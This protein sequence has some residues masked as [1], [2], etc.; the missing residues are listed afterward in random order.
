MITTILEITILKRQKEAEIQTMRDTCSMTYGGVCSAKI[1]CAICLIKDD[2]RELTRL[3]ESGEEKMDFGKI[4]MMTKTFV[5]YNIAFFKKLEDK[6]FN[7]LKRMAPS[8]LLLLNTDR[9]EMMVLMLGLE[10]LRFA[11]NTHFRGIVLS[12]ADRL[13][14]LTNLVKAAI[15]NDDLAP[16]YGT[17][18]KKKRKTSCGHI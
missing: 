12:S 7:L 13:D 9:I 18:K 11:I 1:Y 15:R 10:L 16:L 5:K 6:L 17:I 8:K 14:H 4:T 3:F 2:V